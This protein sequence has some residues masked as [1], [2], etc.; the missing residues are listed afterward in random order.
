[1]V[2]S[3]KI[4]RPSNQA[5]V[6]YEHTS[7]EIR[8]YTRNRVSSTTRCMQLPYRLFVGAVQQIYS[9]VFA[10]LDD[11][12]KVKHLPLKPIFGWFYLQKLEFRLP[13]PLVLGPFCH[14]SEALYIRQDSECWWIIYLKKCKVSKS[15]SENKGRIVFLED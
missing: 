8:Y 5:R 7:G 13:D 14:A 4:W 1:M 11:F 10:I 3:S 2:S 9:Y 6:F 12:F 15:K